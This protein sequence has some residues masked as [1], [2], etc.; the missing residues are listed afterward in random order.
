[1]TE[2]RSLLERAGSNAPPPDLQ[3]ERVLRRRDRK[4]R[5]QRIAAG[6]VGI[7]VFVAAVWIVTSGGWFVRT[8]TPAVPGPTETGPTETGPVYNGP[9]YTLGPVTEEDLALG[10]AFMQ[11][12]VE[13][14]GEAAAAMFSPEG[15]FDGFQPTIF[16]ALYD[17]FRAGGWTFSGGGCGRHGGYGEK[18]APLDV[19]GC[20]F[21]YENDITRA[22]GMRPMPTTLSFVTD[23]G[24][25][26]TAWFGGGGDCC[27]NFFGSPDSVRVLGGGAGD[28]FGPAWDMFIEWLSSHHSEDF[29]RMYDPDYGYP[30]R[31]YP[32][33]NPKSIELWERYTDEFV[34]SPQEL[35]RS[36]TEWMASQSLEVQA[37]RICMIGTEKFW[38]TKRADDLR[39]AALLAALADAS[40]ETLAELRAIPLETEADRATMDEFVPLA[41][42]WIELWRQG[43]AE[44]AT[45]FLYRDSENVRLRFQMDSLIEGCLITGL[46]F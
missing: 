31:G 42:R 41:E 1:M 38:A 6:V 4:R 12:W 17:W 8:E 15:T 40:E 2:Y 10:E 9:T 7:A 39:G 36:F 33:L 13:G 45:D 26:E 34:A 19:V 35:R 30:V 21:T 3:L 43:A 46:G 25:I 22:L 28:L 24:G 27:Y 20:G 44:G 29:G 18:G 23:A 37:A 16:P 32:I 11:A 5:N 14:D